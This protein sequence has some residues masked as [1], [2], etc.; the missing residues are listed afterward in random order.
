MDLKSSS[1]EVSAQQASEFRNLKAPN[2]KS[3][4]RLSSTRTSFLRRF[5]PGSVLPFGLCLMLAVFATATA[6]SQ[7]DSQLA[8]AKTSTHTDLS[9]STIQGQLR[10]HATLTALVTAPGG[11]IPSGSVSFMDGE[12]SVGAAFLDADGRATLTVTALPPGSQTI[13]AVYEGDAGHLTSTSTAASVTSEVSGA[14]SF[15]LSASPTTLSVVAGDTVST[16]ITLTPANGFN[17]AVTLSCSGLPYVSTTCTFSPSPVTP[18]PVTATA[19]NGTPAIS[20]LTITTL[21]PSGSELQLPGNGPKSGMHTAYAIAL[22]GVLALAGLG[23]ARKRGFYGK[24]TSTARMIG[25][26]ALLAAGSLGLGGCSQR[27]KY[28]HRAPADNPGTP[29]GPYTVVITGITG[30]GSTLVTGTISVVLTVT[31]N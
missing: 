7:A 13:T 30:A 11:E 16:V 10:T 15:T 22:P 24:Y 26:F 27:Y 4:A 31:A 6:H 28:F 1:L 25:L 5:L 19:P 12:S 2:L 20:T 23:F 21:A 14:Q 29:T 9:V 17:Q 18:G 3:T 8:V